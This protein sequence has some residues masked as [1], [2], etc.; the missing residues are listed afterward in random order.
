MIVQPQVSIGLSNS[1]RVRCLCVYK[2][3]KYEAEEVRST[4]SSPTTKQCLGH[5]VSYRPTIQVV[6]TYLRDVLSSDLERR[7][8]SSPCT[9]R[10][11]VYLINVSN[12]N[13]AANSTRTYL[14]ICGPLFQGRAIQT[15]KY[16]EQIQLRRSS[17][18]A[19]LKSL[20]AY[21]STVI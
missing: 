12:V 7:L 3:V 14:I 13:T 8:P 4:H 11:I 2:N 15:I 1:R 9:F 20:I 17:G 6:Q 18:F 10:D 21:I 19:E 5:Q 16:S